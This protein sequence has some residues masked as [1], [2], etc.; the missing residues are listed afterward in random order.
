MITSKWLNMR[1]ISW[2]QQMDGLS[3]VDQVKPQKVMRFYRNNLTI[4]VGLKVF[5]NPN[6]VRKNNVIKIRKDIWTFPLVDS[7]A[8]IQ[9]IDGLSSINLD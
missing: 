5:L 7:V 9:P 1:H 8:L 3:S 4:T 6:Y 2:I